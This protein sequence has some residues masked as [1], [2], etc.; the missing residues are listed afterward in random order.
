LEAVI[1]LIP[2]VLGEFTS[3]D[4]ESFAIDTDYAGLLEYPHYTRPPLWNGLEVP[5]VLLSG[6]HEKIKKWRK[7][8]AEQLTKARR[9]DMWQRV[10]EK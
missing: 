5:E 8:Q 2:S 6:H 10:K 7:E 3:V 1:R 9:P 4:E